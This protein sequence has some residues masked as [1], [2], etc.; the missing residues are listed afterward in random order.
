MLNLLD[1]LARNGDIVAGSGETKFTPSRLQIDEWLVYDH[2]AKTCRWYYLTPQGGERWARF[3]KAN[4]DRYHS[5][6]W[7]WHVEDL[8][9]VAATTPEAAERV[10]RYVPVWNELHVLPE[11]LNRSTL[12]PWAATYWKTLPVGYSVRF[13]CDYLEEMF[14]DLDDIPAY[15]FGN[16]SE[17]GMREAYTRVRRE[18]EY[19]HHWY[20]QHPE[21]PSARRSV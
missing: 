6:E 15:F 17:A 4:W 2:P 14:K 3:S 16:L 20:L 8:L 13:R 9:E 1:G 18:F 11:T 21:R 5:F 7:D 10:Y 12:C 19:F